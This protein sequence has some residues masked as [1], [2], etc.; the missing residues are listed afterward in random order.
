MRRRLEAPFDFLHADDDFGFE[1]RDALTVDDAAT[2]ARYLALHRDLPARI[3]REREALRALHVDAVLS[4][5]GYLPIAA[6]RSLGL[7]AFAAC[8]LNWASL[9]QERYLRQG[10]RYADAMR[11]VVATIRD[12]YAAA[13][14]RFA[15]EPGMPFD[16]MGDATRI[17]PVG[18]TGVDRRDALRALLGLPREMRLLLVGFGGVPMALD[19]RRWQ[20]PHG[21]AAL[22]FAAGAPPAAVAAWPFADLVASCDVLVAKP[23]YGTFV[24]AGRVGRD[25]L[26]VPREGWAES[27][28]LMAWLARHAR[29]ETLS[30]EAL[31]HGEFEP[32]LQALASQPGR[33]VAIGDGAAQLAEAIARDL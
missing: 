30:L 19:T 6:A 22:V 33:P 14:G 20:L 12:A 27:P 31:R 16:G 26:V 28:W 1:M 25:T 24:V 18:R 7:P 5:V 17:D 9:L 15:L 32:A 29:L 13:S 8:S 3:E 23:G 11:P 10:G 2:V 4:N 21:W